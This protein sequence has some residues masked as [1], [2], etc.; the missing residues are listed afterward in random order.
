MG[1]WIIDN[2]VKSDL[3]SLLSHKFRNMIIDIIVHYEPCQ[4]VHGVAAFFRRNHPSLFYPI[5]WPILA[6]VFFAG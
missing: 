3:L 4:N 5:P 6:C 2:K 1:L